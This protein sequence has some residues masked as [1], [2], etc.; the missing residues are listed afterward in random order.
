[1]YQD[2]A[3][4]EFIS[5][6]QEGLLMIGYGEDY[7]AAVQANLDFWLRVQ[8]D[9][10]TNPWNPDAP[11]TKAGNYVIVRATRHVGFGE[12]T[13]IGCLVFDHDG[14]QVFHRM[15]PFGRAIYRG[16]LRP[17][18]VRKDHYKLYDDIEDVRQALRSDGHFMSYIQMTE[19]RITHLGEENYESIYH[20]FVLGLH[21]LR[22]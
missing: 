9:R 20:D 3:I 7:I 15:G 12:W 4:E 19:P 17:G 5:D 13:N 21:G 14:K 11:R 6:C 16:D 18:Y 2:C 22:G 1:M 10:K 8:E